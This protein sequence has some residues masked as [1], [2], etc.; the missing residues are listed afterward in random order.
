M[1]EITV[2]LSKQIFIMNNPRNYYALKINNLLDY[3]IKQ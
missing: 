3:Y 2:Y 1:G